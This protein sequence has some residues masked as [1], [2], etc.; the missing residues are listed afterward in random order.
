MNDIKKVLMEH[1]KLTDEKW[2]EILKEQTE[3]FKESYSTIP[4]EI[5]TQKILN[6]MRTRLLRDKSSGRTEDNVVFFGYIEPTGFNRIRNNTF[7][8][9][10]KETDGFKKALAAKLITPNGDL[11]DRWG[12]EIDTEN[13]SKEDI[14]TLIGFNEN[15]E[16]IIG[17]LHDSKKNEIVFGKPC[18]VIFTNSKAKSPIQNISIKN[19]DTIIELDA[20]IPIKDMPSNIENMYMKYLKKEIPIV[21]KVET[22]K[23]SLY[24]YICL[25]GVIQEIHESS[26]GTMF[27]LVTI[28]SEWK[29]TIKVKISNN[30]KN[31][32]TRFINE[33]LGISLIAKVQQIDENENTIV[34]NAVSLWCQPEFII[35]PINLNV[36]IKE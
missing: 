2:D 30:V 15:N 10:M 8:K 23:N 22:I 13:L 24:K 7:K 5:L 35:E 29:C 4:E 16:V 14:H 12:N 28:D 1:Y 26:F 20:E 21:D 27:E 9:I 17:N 32:L 31:F 34:L 36:E 19:I 25:E 33:D 6:S 11:I 3:R 18:Q